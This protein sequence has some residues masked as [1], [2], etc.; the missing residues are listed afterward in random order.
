[1][2]APNVFPADL[3]QE[4]RD[5]KAAVRQLQTGAKRS[6]LVEASAGWVLRQM[7]TPAIPPSGDVHIYASGG[8]LW[9]LSTLDDVPLVGTQFGSS[10]PNTPSPTSGTIG[11]GDSP[12]E[13]EYNALRADYIALRDSYHALLAVLRTGRFPS[14]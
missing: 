1:M 2:T 7:D 10:V 12:T 3:L 5:L 14:P 8:R 11:G 9:A 13:A 6:P 4:I